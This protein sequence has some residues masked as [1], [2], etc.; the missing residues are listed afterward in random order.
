M[1]YII[2]SIK[3]FLWFNIL[4]GAIVVV[5]VLAGGT[6]Y[7]GSIDSLF[8]DGLKSLI[9][10]EVFFG[11]CSALYPLWSFINL[12]D[13]P[14]SKNDAQENA[15]AVRSYM[16]EQHFKLVKEEEAELIYRYDSLAGRISRMGE[17]EV[18]FIIHPDRITV[19]GLRKDVVKIISYLEYKLR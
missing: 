12:K 9:E 1:R 14:S 4:A 3:Y 13:C 17:D 11:V 5:M 10:I 7:D 19:S 18:R 15:E 16:A 6:A 2:R 8:R